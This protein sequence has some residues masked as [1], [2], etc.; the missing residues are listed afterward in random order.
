MQGTC[1]T[2]EYPAASYKRVVGILMS[3]FLVNC[4]LCV[5]FNL[6]SGIYH[7]SFYLLHFCIQ[8]I[9]QFGRVTSFQREFAYKNVNPITKS[10]V[11]IKTHN[12]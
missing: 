3:N 7:A 6:F 5:D 1:L 12:T 9:Y 8:L 10:L 2:E 4:N 11:I